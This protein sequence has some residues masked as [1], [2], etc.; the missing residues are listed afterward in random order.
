V[1]VFPSC[2]RGSTI[3]TRGDGRSAPGPSTARRKRSDTYV[4]N[5]GLLHC[6]CGSALE[7]RSGTG[8]LGRVYFYYACR[9]KECGLRIS[10]EEVEGAVIARLQ[11]T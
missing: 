8:R 3:R 1:G 11:V 5:G 7:G 6:E 9:N 10:A 4:L 2:R